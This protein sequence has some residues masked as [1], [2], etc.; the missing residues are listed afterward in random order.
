MKI[1]EA[2]NLELLE[3]ICEGCIATA[4]FVHTESGDDY[5][6]IEQDGFTPESLVQY[7]KGKMEDEFPWIG[8]LYI[9]GLNWDSTTCDLNPVWEVI[10]NE[11]DKVDIYG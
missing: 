9:K 3:Y 5:L 8:M 4:V 7:L 2:E 10:S 11:L 6:F 1:D